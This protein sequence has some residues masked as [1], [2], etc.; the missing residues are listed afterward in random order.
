MGVARA[1]GPLI[2]REVCGRLRGPGCHV[3]TTVLTT[4]GRLFHK[5][6]LIRRKEGSAFFY[7]AAMPG[8][9]VHRR[10]VKETVFALI[11]RTGVPV[12]AA[13]V[14]AAASQ[15]PVPAVQTRMSEKR[16]S[17]R[18]DSR[19]GS[20]AA[21]AAVKAGRFAIAFSRWASASSALPRRAAAQAA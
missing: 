17:A 2:V 4:L 8:Q 14:N 1:D 13:F 18:S 16:G 12:L 7:S 21:R 9:D 5:G 10:I 19:S 11:E 15:R 3:D 6:L 20:I